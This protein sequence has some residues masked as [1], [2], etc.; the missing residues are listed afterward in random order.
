MI[1]NI[2]ENLLNNI[3]NENDNIMILLNEEFNI[4]EHFSHIIKKK[5]INIYLILSDNTIYNNIIK[6]IKGEECE[7]NINIFMHQFFYYSGII[8]ITF[9]I[10]L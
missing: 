9:P 7:K 6:N 2:I 4:L 8:S 1:I 5:N 10:Y 3:A